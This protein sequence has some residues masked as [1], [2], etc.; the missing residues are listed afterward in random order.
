MRKKIT[1]VD[2]ELSKKNPGISSLAKSVPELVAQGYI[3]NFWGNKLGEELHEVVHKHVKIPC[4]PIPIIGMIINWFIINICALFRYLFVDKKDHVFITTGGHFVLA[5]AAIFQFYNKEW[6]RIQNEGVERGNEPEFYKYRQLWGIFDDYLILKM[7]FCKVFLSASDAIREDLE[8]DHPAKIHITLPNSVDES[9][10]NVTLIEKRDELRE[11]YEISKKAYV[12]VFVSQGHYVRKGFWLAL[13]ALDEYRTRNPGEEVKFLV[14]GGREKKLSGIKDHL[15]QVYPDWREWIV[16][17]GWTDK[18]QEYMA[19][20]D[21]LFFP[22]YFEAFSLVEIEAAAMRLPLILT[23]HHG[24]EMILNEGVNGYLCD[25]DVESI[26]KVLEK[27]RNAPLK[28]E[29]PDL[30]KALTKE[31]WTDQFQ[32]IITKI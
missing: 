25:F 14:L 8:R 18:V 27:L 21:A 26:V 3:V 10:F 32:T 30:G 2:Y 29:E 13:K 23:K 15:D 20:S 31:S 12:L 11:K 6:Y 24:S 7:P 1:I 16:F 9:V 17:T 5:D 28:I 22:S 4:V 19:F